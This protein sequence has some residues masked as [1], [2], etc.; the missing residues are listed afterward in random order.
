M[1][2]FEYFLFLFIKKRLFN[3]FASR[4]NYTPSSIL[5]SVIISYT[6]LKEKGFPTQPA[7]LTGSVLSHVLRDTNAH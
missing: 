6:K 4:Y 1:F 2:F 3:K 7:R 5:L